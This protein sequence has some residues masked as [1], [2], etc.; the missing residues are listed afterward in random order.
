MS[1]TQNTLLY[2]TSSTDC[3]CVAVVCSACREMFGV[4][5]LLAI[6]LEINTTAPLFLIMQLFLSKKS[7]QLVF[8][9]NHPQNAPSQV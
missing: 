3:M 5:T 8:I 2:L 6:Q 9:L 7:I 1:R 4:W